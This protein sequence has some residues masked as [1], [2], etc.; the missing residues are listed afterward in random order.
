M[1]LLSNHRKFKN[2]T[3]SVARLKFISCK[4]KMLNYKNIIFSDSVFFKFMWCDCVT[5]LVY[6][7][8][9]LRSILRDFEQV[10]VKLVKYALPYVRIYANSIISSIECNQCANQIV[11][12]TR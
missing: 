2:N 3:C 1:T 10:A 11:S 7:V 9:M 8:P 12:T 4:F 5:I 6:L